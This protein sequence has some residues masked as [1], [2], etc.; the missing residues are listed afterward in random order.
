MTGTA[1]AGATQA[2]ALALGDDALILG[3]RLV[4]WITHA[5]ELEEEVALANIALDLL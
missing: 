5:P 1:P 2:Y 4:E 3:Q